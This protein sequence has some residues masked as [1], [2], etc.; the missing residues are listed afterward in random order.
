MPVVVA[1]PGQEADEL[2][3]AAGQG[4]VALM[5]SAIGGLV[6]MLG[7]V[8]KKFLELVRKIFD[9]D[10]VPRSVA[11]ELRNIRSDVDEIKRDLKAMSSR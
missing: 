8:F 9:G 4:P 6:I 2:V 7:Y 3:E 5:A 10:L 11:D 1:G